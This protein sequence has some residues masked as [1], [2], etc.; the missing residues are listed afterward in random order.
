MAE[1]Y[2]KGTQCKN[3]R[4]KKTLQCVQWEKFNNMHANSRKRPEINDPLTKTESN[5]ES[6]D[7]G[8]KC[9]PV[10]IVQISLV[11]VFYQLNCSIGRLITL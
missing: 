3:L 5:N 10:K 8:V 11:C 4:K 9:T 1:K 6:N 2:Q 7:G